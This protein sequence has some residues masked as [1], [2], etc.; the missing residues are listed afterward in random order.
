MSISL[1]E[2][3]I[4]PH[5]KSVL[6][7]GDRQKNLLFLILIIIIG[8]Y[9]NF[10][11][12]GIIPLSCIPPPS[13]YHA[14]PLGKTGYKKSKELTVIAKV[15]PTPMMTKRYKIFSLKCDIY[16]EKKNNNRINADRCM[17]VAARIRNNPFIFLPLIII[18]A[19]Q[20]PIYVAIA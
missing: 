4:I 10:V 13:I 2:K 1:K 15:P 14:Y 17:V 8:K 19:P 5:I 7:N 9:M 12:I 6:C 20:E 18:M 3:P 11:I 16:F